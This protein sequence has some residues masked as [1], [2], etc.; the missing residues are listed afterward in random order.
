MCR[1]PGSLRRRVAIM[2]RQLRS[3]RRRSDIPRGFSC[4]RLR[5][6]PRI[7]RIRSYGATLIVG[8]ALYADA[9]AASEAWAQESGALP[10]HGAIS[11][12]ILDFRAR[13]LVIQG[14]GA[15]LT[16]NGTLI[17]GTGLCPSKTRRRASRVPGSPLPASRRMTV[18]SMCHISS[19]RVVRSP[20]LGFAGCT[21]EPRAAPA[22]LP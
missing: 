13:V 19:A 17:S 18:V 5:R 16:G 15:K 22:V 9:L 14:R 21:Q 7:D 10:I 20:I 4:R 3:R 2:A 8:G 6:P 1:R 11:T 12:D